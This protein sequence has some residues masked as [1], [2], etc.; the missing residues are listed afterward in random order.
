[1]GLGGRGEEVDRL[2]TNPPAV[3]GISC[4]HLSVVS[5]DIG[6]GKRCKCRV[7]ASSFGL[8]FPFN[9]KETTDTEGGV[10]G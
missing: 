7:L 8:S 2:I 3:T 5:L 6:E 9:L 4:A 10:R 1:M